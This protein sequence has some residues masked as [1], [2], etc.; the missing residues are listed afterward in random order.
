MTN[1]YALSDWG[2]FWVKVQSK[3]PRELSTVILDSNIAEIVL[4]DIKNF[5][6]NAEWYVERGVPYRRGYMLY[7]PPGTGKTSFVLAIAAEMKFSI[8]T[9]NLSGNELDDETLN[10][11]LECAPKNAII[12]LEDIDAIFVAR[13]SVGEQREGRKVKLC[14][15][16]Q[17]FVLLFYSY[18]YSF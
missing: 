16:F 5:Q 18:A 2:G 11:V 9:L 4:N 13:E 17:F 3:K 8:C 10:K 15:F 7:G 14:F 1:I 12:L 6:S